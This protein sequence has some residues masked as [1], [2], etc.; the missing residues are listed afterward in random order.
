[1]PPELERIAS[2]EA[3]AEA[4]EEAKKKL[5]V[6][7]RCRDVTPNQEECNIESNNITSTE[8]TVTIKEW[9]IHTLKTMIPIY[10]LIYLIKQSMKKYDSKESLVEYSRF[11]LILLIALLVISIAASMIGYIVMSNM[12]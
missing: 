4:Y 5:N 1:M 9:F 2:G 12:W 7:V 10:G 8:Q 3:I 6:Q 11:Q